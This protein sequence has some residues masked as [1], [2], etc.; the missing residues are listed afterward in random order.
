MQHELTLKVFYR[1]IQ[2]ITSRLNAVGIS[3][4]FYTIPIE[5]VP[6]ENGYDYVENENAQTE[7]K[8]YVESGELSD[9]GVRITEVLKD[10]KYELM[11]QAA[12][13]SEEYPLSS[14]LELGNGWIICSPDRAVLNNTRN[15]LLYQSR[16]SLGT[17][18][19]GTT[20]G[21]LEFI[22]EEDFTGKSVLDL[23]TGSGILSV[24][25]GL[26]NAAFI[27]AV[28]IEPL[29]EEVEHHFALNQLNP[30]NAYYQAD[31]TDPDWKLNRDYD[32]IFMNITAR[33]IIQVIEKSNLLDSCREGC[34][35]SGLVE[36]NYRKINDFFN[37]AG[38][39]QEEK[40]EID[41]WV[42]L[43]FKKS[44]LDGLG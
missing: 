34:L 20:Q 27:V 11:E 10:H 23:G 13:A 12:P 44:G 41:G 37:R 40:M 8:I 22:L 33:H 36:W 6:D 18:L 28:D 26:K 19:N 3:Q 4:L 29:K 16:G 7:L 35:V 42:T 14:S 2:E 17:E 25:A 32:W 15:H 30:I 21:C 24:A 38:F 1:D 5:V 39:I 9:S 43:L 31:I